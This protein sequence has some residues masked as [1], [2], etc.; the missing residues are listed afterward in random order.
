MLAYIEPVW[1]FLTLEPKVKSLPERIC[2]QPQMWNTVVDFRKIMN[3]RH[4]MVRREVATAMPAKIVATWLIDD[5]QVLV[6]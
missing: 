1:F 2:I 5:G 4:M 3:I 6:N